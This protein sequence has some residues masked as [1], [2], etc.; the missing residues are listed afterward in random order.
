MAM[1]RLD[2]VLV[3][4]L[5]GP[6]QAAVYAATT[7][8]LV[9]GQMGGSAVATAVQP[10]IGAAVAREDRVLACRLYGT[11]TAWLVLITWP[12]YLTF[13]TFGPFLLRVFGEGYS[14]GAEALTLLSLAMLVATGCGMVDMVLNMAGRTT[15]T[16]GNTLFSLVLLVG[17]D[18]WLIPAYGIIGAAIGWSLARVVANLVPLALLGLALRL[19]PF[20]LPLVTAVT[21][22]S[23]CFGVGLVL[24]RVLLGASWAGLAAGVV[25]AGLCYL[26]ALLL[27]RRPLE[28]TALAGLR[29]RSRG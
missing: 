24:A 18:L 3:A 27:L 20:G 26:V 16:L 11:S 9:L 5:I 12:I 2:I 21:A 19:H 15:W 7:R 6:L 13:A 25:G 1:Q 28:L 17:L 10:R 8:F 22:S 29:G 14:E 4:A 23:L